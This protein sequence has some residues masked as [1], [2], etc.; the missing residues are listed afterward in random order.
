[1]TKGVQTPEIQIPP[2]GMAPRPDEPGG[3]GPQALQAGAVWRP[4][5][6]LQLFDNHVVNDTTERVSPDVECPGFRKFHL[7]VFLDSTSTPTTL[8]VKVQFLDRW[9]GRWSTY[10][11]GPFAALFWE[12]TDVAD[13]VSECFHGEVCGRAMRVTLTGVGT[14]A[15]AYFTVSVAV[16]FRS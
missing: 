13:G 14:S 15:Q 5:T 11:Q 3:R 10:K 2:P 12:D 8:Q 6:Q 4:K 1:M 9:S 7:H 16:D